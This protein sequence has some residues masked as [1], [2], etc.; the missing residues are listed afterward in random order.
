[1]ASSVTMK[2]LL[3]AVLLLT[4]PRADAAMICSLKSSQADMVVVMRSRDDVEACRAEM[5]ATG[6]P[7]IICLRAIVAT[8][9]NSTKAQYLGSAGFASSLTKIRILEGEDVGVEG[10]VQSSFCDLPK[11]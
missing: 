2:T 9:P 8:V 4:A 3:V 11:E 6:K 10:V 5:Q 1:M 7:A